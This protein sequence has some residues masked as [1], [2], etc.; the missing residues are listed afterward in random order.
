MSMSEI[1]VAFLVIFTPGSRIIVENLENMILDSLLTFYKA[2]RGLKGTESPLR[3]KEPF[4][5]QVN[6]IKTSDE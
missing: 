4:W 6:T 3:G 1:S 5:V 2:I